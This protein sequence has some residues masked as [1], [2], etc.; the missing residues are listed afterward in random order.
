ML[1]AKDLLSLSVDELKELVSARRNMTEEERKALREEEEKEARA[2]A[3]ANG[4]KIE[5]DVERE[6]K[7]EEVTVLDGHTSEVFHMRVEPD[8]AN[9]G[10]R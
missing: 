4:I 1:S 9:A 8:E 6:I 2:K 3:E 10:E 7:S 5:S